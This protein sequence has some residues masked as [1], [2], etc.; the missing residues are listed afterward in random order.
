MK[1]FSSFRDFSG[2][3]DSVKLLV[4][5]YTINPQNLIKIIVAIFEKIKIFNFL[6]C[7]LPLI[8]GVRGKLKKGLQI[9]T[10]EL[11]ISNLNEIG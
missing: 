5:E 6:S 9:F 4:F 3:A 11:Y 8:L 2:K 10:R 7:E 1:Y